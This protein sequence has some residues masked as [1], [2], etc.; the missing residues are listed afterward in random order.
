ML[1]IPLAR[2]ESASDSLIRKRF[3][4]STDLQ[5]DEVQLKK[6][7]LEL[8]EKA[9]QRNI[10]L[11]TG[12]LSLAE[13]ESFWQCSGQI[14]QDNFSLFGGMEDAER[15]MIRFGNLKELGYE[16]EFPIV[17]IH[18]Y[19]PQKKFAED[20]THRDF[21]GALMNLGIERSL[22]GDI[23]VQDREAWLFC[24]ESIAPFLMENLTRVRH[25]NVNCEVQ[26]ELPE[27]CKRQLEIREFTVASER[28]D[29]VVSRLY[30]IARSNGAALFTTDKV[31]VNGRLM[32]KTTYL[33]KPQDVVSVRGFGKFVYYGTTR[34][35]K[36]GRLSVSV[37]VYR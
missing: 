30:N 36:K 33:L 25:T 16:Q 22:L 15:V 1:R 2:K 23:L 32:E 27:I 12:F 6:R 29:A 10:F 3:C 13:Q 5:K 7:F 8:S 35:T 26:E 17:C 28:I 34:E 11:F 21:L 31:W 9:Y 24:N 14:A 19:P 4:M 37:G 20:L 18:L